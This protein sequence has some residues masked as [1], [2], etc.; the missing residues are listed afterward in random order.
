MN[1]V[2]SIAEML[3]L[4]EK[5]FAEGVDAW[6]LMQDAGRQMARAIR[7]RYPEPGVCRVFA[8]KGNNGGDAWVVAFGLQQAGWDVDVKCPFSDPELSALARRAAAAWAQRGNNLDRSAPP[9][10]RRPL[11]VL[12]GLLGIGVKGEVRSPLRE[13][14]EEIGRLRADGAVVFSLDLPSGLGTGTC[15]V[16]D[17][18]LAVG[19]AKEELLRDEATHFVGRI[20]VLPLGELSCR[21][22][23]GE[24]RAQQSADLSQMCVSG[25]GQ[26]GTARPELA[27]AGSLRSLLPPRSFDVH[28]GQC[29]RVTI[30]AGSLGTTG[31]AVL[32]AMGALR[33]GAGLV[34]LFCPP[35]IHPIL[36]P[37]L[38]PEVMARPWEHPA[39]IADEN[40]DVLAIGPGLDP[41][42]GDEIWSLIERVRVPLVLDAGALTILARDVS[43]LRHIPVPVLLTPHP[44]EMERL[45]PQANRSR[46]RWA[47]NF[48]A[49]SAT[50]KTTLL[51]KGS[52]TLVAQAGFPM[53]FNPTGHPGMATGGMGDTLT[54][55]CAALLAQKLS[56]RDAARVGA[57][58]CGRAAEI[59]I[60]D[61]T[62]SQESLLPTDLAD[63]LGRAFADLRAGVY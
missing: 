55:V 61:G 48:V 31:A 13:M 30:V 32:A 40:M 41:R 12:D 20:S 62:Q 4:E 26:R 57:W 37:M 47:A 15:V 52:R 49:T 19:F 33:G 29:G 8:G 45:F 46:I 63:Q 5:A 6:S 51:L 38:P 14:I 44:G 60:E 2:V 58:V 53:T 22:A 50:K 1:A 56:T 10:G 43:R 17:H 21:W 9:D 39:S 18:T 34:S 25:E 54:G 23:E 42:W 11:I 36:A 24:R 27:T 7:Q 16:A 59:A 3:A 28:K 35:E